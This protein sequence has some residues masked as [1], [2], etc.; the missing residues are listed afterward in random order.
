MLRQRHVGREQNLV[1][2]LVA[3]R[4][5]DCVIGYQKVEWSLVVLLEDNFALNHKL[6]GGQIEGCYGN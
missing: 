1:I 5:A 3:E 6:A 2:G 4:V